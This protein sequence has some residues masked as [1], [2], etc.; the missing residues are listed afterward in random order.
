MAELFLAKRMGLDGFEK[1]VAIKQI[2][3]HLSHEEEFVNMFRDEARIV[4]K[5]SHPNIVQ[6]YDLGKSEDS[7]FIAMEYIPGRNLSSVAKRAKSK[8]L[9]LEPVYVARCIAQAC[10]GLYYAHNRKE[11]DGQ[12]LRIVHRDV[13]PQNIILAFSGQIKIVD[14]GIAKA[15]TKIA[16]TRHGVLKGKYAYMSPEQIRGEKIDARSDLFA[17]GV[18]LYELLCGRRPFEKENSIQT[19]KSIVQEPHESPSSINSNLDDTLVGIIDKCLVKKRDDRFQTAQEVQIALEDYVAGSGIRS[20]NLA[21][22]QWLNDL[23]AED[24]QKAKG[25]TVVFKGVGEVILPESES[26]SAKRSSPARVR[27][28]SKPVAPSVQRAAMSNGA[29][30]GRN[31]SISTSGQSEKPKAELERGRGGGSLDSRPPIQ[32]PSTRLPPARRPSTMSGERANLIQEGVIKAP[33]NNLPEV[34]GGYLDDATAIAPPEFSDDT[35]AEPAVLPAANPAPALEPVL[36]PVSRDYSEGVR[37]GISEPT[38]ESGYDDGATEFSPSIS[39]DDVKDLSALDSAESPT[40]EAMSSLKDIARDKGSSKPVVTAG[41]ESP[42]EIA[43]R[44]TDV[45]SARSLTAPG[46]IVETVAPENSPEEID[47]FDD[48]GIQALEVV[49]GDSTDSNPLAEPS[50]PRPEMANVDVDADSRTMATADYEAFEAHL[51]NREAFAAKPTNQAVAAI[52][53]EDPF[54]AELNAISGE[55]RRSASQIGEK[56]PD[57]APDPAE[58]ALD[59]DDDTAALSPI[60]DK[61]PSPLI[62]H[63]PPKRGLSWGNDSE[64]LPP[65]TPSEMEN[66]IPPAASEPKSANPNADIG[67][68]QVPPA[69]VSLSEMLCE[70]TSPPM[71]VRAPTPSGLEPVA[72]MPDPDLPAMPEVSAAPPEAP[73]GPRV[74]HSSV[75]KVSAVRSIKETSR[76]ESNEELAGAEPAQQPE[77]RI[78]TPRSDSDGPRRLSPRMAG[79]GTGAK[80]ATEGNEVE[81]SSSPILGK[82]VRVAKIILFTLMFIGAAGGVT[83]ALLKLRVPTLTVETNPPGARVFMDGKLLEGSTPLDTPVTPGQKY[84]LK[85]INEGYEEVRRNVK[86]RD[87]IAPSLLQID[88]TP[89]K[90]S[91]KPASP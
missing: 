29:A 86:V 50:L 42:E 41:K 57:W 65:G 89:K 80:V 54:E 74:R 83:Y 68:A 44:I 60:V 31:P 72:G 25:S 53:D 43:A 59:D 66:L 17:V 40:N 34:S 10:E 90:A 48:E 24:L 73:R 85:I 20:S 45:R 56:K 1:V 70:P 49:V 16:H 13:S 78:N 51:A 15:A 91:A 37:D 52:E 71:P 33:S 63:T 22:S 87:S 28:S 55:L 5:L 11:P 21:I 8:N 9:A 3:P 36:A 77:L 67:S 82:L 12:P 46:V 64:T 47:V 79:A 7:Y 84:E 4:A 69:N 26:G 27:S 76:H 61:A 39:D 23:F 19:L 6:I 2:L 32:A 18:V 75:A 35:S 88:L 38:N 30:E 58:M 14:F 81:K 62:D